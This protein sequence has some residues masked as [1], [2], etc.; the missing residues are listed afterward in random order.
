MGICPERSRHDKEAR[1]ARGGHRETG[2]K[3]YNARGQIIQS[4]GS[5]W[6][7]S[8]LREIRKDGSISRRVLQRIVVLTISLRVGSLWGTR[9]TCDDECHHPSK[10]HWSVTSVAAVESEK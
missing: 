6:W 1:V 3:A 2:K 5:Q 8:G 9:V 7:V 4:L 10:A